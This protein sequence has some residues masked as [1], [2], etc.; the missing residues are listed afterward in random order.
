MKK[1]IS[2][3]SLI[4]AILVIIILASMTVFSVL[5]TIEQA[6]DVKKEKEFKDVVTYVRSISNKIQSRTID[7]S[8]T[9][10]TLASAEQIS[11]MYIEN[12]DESELLA[13]EVNIVNSVNTA[14]KSGDSSFGADHGC[15]YVTSSQIKYGIDGIDETSNLDNVDNDYI[16]NFYY[17]VVI[18]RISSSKTLVDGIIK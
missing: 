8:L 16:I 17:G 4:V 1:G 18:A 14:I 12:S 11:S 2:L 6:Q 7:V 15:H 3:V 9:E 13:D 5:D 10:S